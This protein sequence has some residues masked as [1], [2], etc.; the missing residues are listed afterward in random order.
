MRA[1]IHERLTERLRA[2]A[3]VAARLA[4]LEGEVAAGRLD[5]T[6]AAEDIVTMLERKCPSAL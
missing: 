4:A 5:P 6:S 1:T 3:A 2:D